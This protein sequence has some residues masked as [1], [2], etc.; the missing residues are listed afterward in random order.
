MPQC[1]KVSSL[2]LLSMRLVYESLPSP[3]VSVPSRIL[4]KALIPTFSWC[5][6]KLRI[7]PT[8]GLSAFFFM[9]PL[10]FFL[11]LLLILP[12]STS[13][14]P[15]QSLNVVYRNVPSLAALTAPSGAPKPSKVST[16]TAECHILV[17]NDVKTVKALPSLKCFRERKKWIRR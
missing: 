13:L 4:T 14:S 17:L 7:K 15:D 16:G 3:A 10:P 5:V 12:T 1:E 11:Y 8:R 9:S 6:K 2:C